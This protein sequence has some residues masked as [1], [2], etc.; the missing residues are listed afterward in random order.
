MTTL[1]VYKMFDNVTLPEYGTEDSACFDVRANLTGTDVE[2]VNHN[3]SKKKLTKSIVPPG[4][5]GNPV[6]EITLVKGDTVKVPTGLILDIPTGYYVE[7]FI[8]SS[9]VWKKGLMM[10]NSTAIIDNDYVDELFIMVQSISSYTT[11]VQGERLAQGRLV[12]YE[13]T[14][15][16]ETVNKPVQKT[17]RIGGIGSTGRH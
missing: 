6:E 14:P 3:G 9:S 15:I 13:K 8:R 4:Y 17:D 2:Y 1:N 11:I 7:L 12:K 16:Q 5:S 10:A